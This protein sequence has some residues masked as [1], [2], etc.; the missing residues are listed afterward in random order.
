M[1]L[2]T[3]IEPT[4]IRIKKTQKKAIEKGK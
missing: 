3:R 1:A 2:K 4:N